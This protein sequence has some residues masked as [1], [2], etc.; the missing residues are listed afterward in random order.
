M[1]RGTA[2]AL[3]LSVR[4]VARRQRVEDF[5]VRDDHAVASGILL[6]RSGEF[7]YV[8]RALGCDVVLFG[9][10][11]G[12]VIQLPRSVAVGLREM[13]R[14]P[15]PLADRAHAVEFKA[16]SAARLGRLCFQTGSGA[17]YGHDVGHVHW[18]VGGYSV[19][20]AA[21]RRADDGRDL[22]AALGEV[23]LGQAQRRATCPR[24]SGADVRRRAGTSAVL[25]GIVERREELAKEMPY[26]SQRMALIRAKNAGFEDAVHLERSQSHSSSS[27]EKAIDTYVTEAIASG[28]LIVPGINALYEQVHNEFDSLI[29]E[30]GFKLNVK[31]FGTKVE[32][33]LWKGKTLEALEKIVELGLSVEERFHRHHAAP[34]LYVF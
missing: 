34:N 2:C 18:S 29:K 32:T 19:E 21:I 25:Q 9:R 4:T 30:S 13:E 26:V 10:I 27:T 22:N 23:A 8:L 33:L 1:R 20:R 11:T 6:P 3:G 12:K 31:D 24:P 17:H 14:F 16:E 15:V 5:P 7:C 28:A